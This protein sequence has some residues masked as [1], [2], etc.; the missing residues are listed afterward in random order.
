MNEMKTILNNMGIGV[1]ETE[2]IPKDHSSSLIG[3]FSLFIYSSFHEMFAS[4]LFGGEWKQGKGKKGRN[5]HFPF[6]RIRFQ[7]SPLRIFPLQA[8]THKAT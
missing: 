1:G 7:E 6:I 8:L 4:L 2:V 5:N 3:A